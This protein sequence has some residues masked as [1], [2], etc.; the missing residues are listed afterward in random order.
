MITN[1]FNMCGSNC[2]SYGIVILGSTTIQVVE[3]VVS[4]VAMYM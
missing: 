3:W 2:G 1:A 4:S